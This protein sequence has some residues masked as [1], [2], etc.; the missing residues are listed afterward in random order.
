M[1]MNTLLESNIYNDFILNIKS[2]LEMAEQ[3]SKTISQFKKLL[4]DHLDPAEKD[5]DIDNVPIY[6]DDIDHHLHPQI[7]EYLTNNFAIKQQQYQVFAQINENLLKLTKE[8]PNISQ[9]EMQKYFIEHKI[10]IY[11]IPVVP[12]MTNK[13]KI[14]DNQKFI[15]GD[16][17][18]EYQLSII[19]TPNKN[20]LKETIVKYGFDYLEEI[21]QYLP[22]AGFIILE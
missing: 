19:L 5:I 16:K 21:D 3:A 15:W 6:L 1:D 12:S 2:Y 4:I 11:I 17:E 10:P 22:K 7:Q 8:F 20:Y 13:F 9:L 14:Y 18:Q